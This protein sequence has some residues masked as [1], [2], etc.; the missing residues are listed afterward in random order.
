VLTGRDAA[1]SV[2]K[3][4]MAR[5]DIVHLATHA[6][7]DEAQPRY[8]SIVLATPAGSREDG[9]LEARE[10]EFL[11][12]DAQMVILSACNTARGQGV[13]GEGVVGLAWALLSKG[14]RHAVVSQWKADS[15]ATTGLMVAFHRHLASGDAPASAL[16]KAQ[17]ELR[18]DPRY[19]DPLY[20]APFIVIGAP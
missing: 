15:K 3:N 7:I 5:Y 2:V 19:E 11:D 9:L 16:R 12:L 20:W 17:L 8:S 18:R 6:L 14:V 1:E 13:A 10:L 4:E